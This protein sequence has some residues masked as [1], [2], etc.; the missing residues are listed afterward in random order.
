MKID[1]YLVNLFFLVICRST[2]T[3]TTQGFEFS[4]TRGKNRNAN[5]FTRKADGLL[6]YLPIVGSKIGLRQRSKLP[7]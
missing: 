5:I 3:R 2:H 1:K 6:K 7:N 4:S